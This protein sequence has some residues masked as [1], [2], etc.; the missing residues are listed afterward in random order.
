[1][2]KFNSILNKFRIMKNQTFTEGQDIWFGVFSDFEECKKNLNV[3]TSFLTKLD[4]SILKKK[5]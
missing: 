5:N 1:M 2:S 3:K 4:G